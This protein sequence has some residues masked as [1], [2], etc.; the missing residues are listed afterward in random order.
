MKAIIYDAVLHL[1]QDH[2]LRS[3]LYTQEVRT[4]S[5]HLVEPEL[6]P[7]TEPSTQITTTF[8]MNECKLREKKKPTREKRFFKCEN[9]LSDGYTCF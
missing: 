9:L 8:R 7:P 2:F 1:K 5:N 4:F 6:T 3:I